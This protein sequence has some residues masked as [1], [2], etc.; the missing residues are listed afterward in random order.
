MRPELNA[1]KTPKAALPRKRILIV[2]CYF[3]DTRQPLR[4]TTKVP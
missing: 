2:N 3:D 4:R 1:I